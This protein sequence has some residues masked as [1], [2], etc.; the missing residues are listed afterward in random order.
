[1]PTS[2]RDLRVWQR[3]MDLAC[4]IYGVTRLLPADE[5]FGLKSQLRRSAVS[6]PVNIAEG[7]GRATTKELLH[8]ISIARGSLKEIE[9]LLTVCE[10]LTMLSPSDLVNATELCGHVS[11]GLWGLR[12]R[13]MG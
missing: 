5:R 1:M 2:Y 4:E 6:V 7:S 12:K 8:F 10:R 11:R 9:T 3:A 13:L